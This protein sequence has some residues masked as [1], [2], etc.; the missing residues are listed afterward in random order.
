MAFTQNIGK[1]PIDKLV[2]KIAGGKQKVDNGKAKVQ[3]VRDAPRNAAKSVKARVVGKVPS[4]RELCA[5]L[6]HKVKKGKCPRC[7]CKVL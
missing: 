6:G 7:Q 4:G 5:K 3:A 1:N 2:D